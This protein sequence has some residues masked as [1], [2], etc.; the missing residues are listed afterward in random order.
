MSVRRYHLH[1]CPTDHSVLHWLAPEVLSQA[2]QGYTTKADIYSV[3][4]LTLELL[5]GEQ[6]YASLELA[7]VRVRVRVD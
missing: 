2:V 4:I 6:P 1:Y 7:Q 3:G 5:N